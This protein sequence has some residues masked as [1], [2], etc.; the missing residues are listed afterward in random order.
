MCG[1]AGLCGWRGDWKSNLN[2]MC[3]RMRHR[4]PDGSGLWAE[5][6]GSVALGHRTAGHHRSVGNRGAAHAVGKRQVRDLL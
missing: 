3:E 2:R 1:I 5:E 6:D 4:G